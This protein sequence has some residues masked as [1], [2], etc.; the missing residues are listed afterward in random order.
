[1][2]IKKSKSKNSISYSIIEDYKNNGKRTTR[3]VETLGNIEQIKIK[4]VN[5]DPFVWMNEYV[6]ELN[7]E[8]EKNE[9]IVFLRLSQ[10]K[11]SKSIS[12]LP[13]MVVICSYKKYIMI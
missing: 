8:K 2:R 1:M 4:A 5:K 7:R 3:I 13:S 12:K 9:G 10:N 11:K 6:K